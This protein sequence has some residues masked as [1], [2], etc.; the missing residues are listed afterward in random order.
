MIHDR[1]NVTVPFTTIGTACVVAGGLVSAAIAPS[2]TTHGSWAVAYLV[3]VGGVAQITL[4]L[5]QAM[6]APGLPERRRVAAE[7]V[8]WNLGN[9]LVMTGTLT[10]ILT[11]V[12]VGGVILVAGLALLATAVKGGARNEERSRQW[13]LYGYRVLVIGLLVSIPTGLVL[14]RIGPN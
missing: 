14:A 13:L 11:L 8:A 3:L 4:G 1:K 6:L 12:D 10:G 2:P 7:L 5:G 9:A